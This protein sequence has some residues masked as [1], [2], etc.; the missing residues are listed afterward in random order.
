MAVKTVPYKAQGAKH[1]ALGMDD[2]QF[3]VRYRAIDARDVRFDGQFFTAVS[4][5][6]VYCR[7]SCPAKT[8]KRENV[9][10]YPN[11][12]AAQGAGYRACKRCFPEATPGTPEWNLRDDL[13]ARAMRLVLDGLVDRQGVEGLARK[14]GY[15]PRHIN[16]VMMSQLG[17]GP[18][19]LARARRAQSARNLLTE[20]QLPLADVAFAAG[21]GS[22][23]QFNVTMQQVFDASPSEIRNRSVLRRMS[24]NLG[25]TS[26]LK[27]V[28]A[29][30]STTSRGHLEGESAMVQIQ[31][32][33]PVREPFDAAGV[34]NFLAVRAVTDIEVVDVSRA[35]SFSYARSILLPGGP[36]AVQAT[37]ELSKKGGWRIRAKLELSSLADVA[38]A[39]ARL[40]RLFD[41]DADPQAVDAALS[42]DQRL[43]PLVEAT[44]GIRVPGAVDAQELVVRAMVGQQ[45]TVVAARNHLSRLVAHAG[46]PFS[47]S[48]A[49]LT[50]L[51]PSPEQIVAAVRETG[52]DDTLDPERPLRLPRRS[53][54][55]IRQACQAMVAGQ[56]DLDVSADPRQLRDALVAMPGIGQW[57]A[58]YISMRVLGDPDAWLIGD[59]ALIAGARAAG[60]LDSELSK[61]SSHKVLAQIAHAW[62]PWRSYAAMH[63]WQAA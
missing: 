60:I 59:V 44:P 41:L 11:S 24:K 12:A 46:S 53:S 30:P 2:P 19:R 48:F 17:A 25:S 13:A 32:D 22:V 63:L 38:P 7:P 40:R 27:N 45:I 39:T 21:F 42:Q 58:E 6:G 1:A 5:T 10:F 26:E 35:D 62:S 31:L 14:L 28:A 23:R 34:F 61:A 29:E 51:F 33:L 16:R 52:P 43:V 47:S 8:P 54:N 9:S 36:A 20:C 18:L 49:G 55:A 37:A 50:R 15:T 4:S 57:T 3:D 56:L